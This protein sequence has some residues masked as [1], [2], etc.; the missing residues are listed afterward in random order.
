M[1]RSHPHVPILLRLS[2]RV[3]PPDVRE[4]VLGDL[5]E[6]WR[7]G[8]RERSWIRRTSWLLRQPVSASVA[9][10]RFRSGERTPTEIPR[11]KLGAPFSWLDVKLGLRMMVKHPGISLVIVFALALGIP[12]SLAPHHLI[13]AAVDESPPFDEGH[14]V[15][16]FLTVE[17]RPEDPNQ[18]RATDYALLREGLSSFETLGAA[19]PGEMNVISLEGAAHGVHGAWMSASSFALARVP[20]LM[21]RVLSPGDEVEGAPDVVV[22][23]FDFWRARMGGDPDVLGTTLRVGGVP[24]TVVGVMPQGFS[25]PSN[26]QLWLP[27]R[28]PT[29]GYS[30]ELGPRVVTY[31]RLADGVSLAEAQAEL[32][33]MGSRA[34]TT[35]ARQ[36]VRIEA[37]P[38]SSL[39]FDKPQGG[40]ASILLTL[41]QALPLL[42]LLIAC[43]NVGILLLARTATRTGEVAIRAALGAS[44]GRIVG[45][46]FVE[47][48][49]LALVATGVGL[50]AVEAIVNRVQPR[51]DL[52]FWMDLGVT[53]ELAAKAL[54]LAVF[55]AVVAGVLPALRAT[56]DGLHRSLQGAR[57]GGGA[58]RFGPMVTALVVAEVALG[59]GALFAGGITLYAFRPNPDPA[60]RGVDVDRYLVASISV[61]RPPL[62]S[63]ADEPSGE[64]QRLRVATVQEELARRL[65]SEPGVRGWSFSDVPVGGG[66]HERMLRIDG[67]AL[68]A[69]HPGLVGVTTLVDPAFF[70]ILDVEPVA[71]RLFGAADV[72]AD[73]TADPTV[74]VV[75]MKFLER[76]GMAATT[77]IGRSLRF[78]DDP[79]ERPGPW[80]EIVGAVPNVEISADRMMFDGTPM[81]Y[82]PAVT[83]ALQ[84]T[85]L[86]VDV[87]HDPSAFA[88][89]LRSLLADTDPTAILQNASALEDRPNDATV[90]SRVLTSVMGGLSLIAILLSTAALYALMALTVSQRRRE[91]GIR[92][93]LG[94]EPARIVVTVA[95]RALGQLTVGVL[96]GA[97][98]WVALLSTT[99]GGSD[100]ELARTI[101]R[102]PYVL[103]GAVAIV[104]TVGLT[105]CLTPALRGVRIRPVDALRAEG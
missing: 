64:E 34:R 57:G 72:P 85:T 56:R 96:L 48:L 90:V 6:H 70:E 43:G 88:P 99:L 86:T 78:T 8:V 65:G 58:L 23:G 15:V 80:M 61:P 35:P 24:T 91:I 50:F 7:T 98:F 26:E 31:G 97:G 46:L 59:L 76:R 49:L 93:A 63:S 21:G 52:P 22:I 32:R 10:L 67:D 74:V 36:M 100:G 103:L 62:G 17:G 45:Q 30:D 77:S 2:A 44:R 25:M 66:Q 68:P 55:S 92:I 27:L 13:D 1:S 28:L 11:G 12:A 33:V 14:D 9:R 81:V 37:V 101:A 20:P 84:P 47:A 102:W 69:D 104:V 29:A 5:V 19:L 71:G 3:L 53:A 94:G 82:L 41:A 16:G 89:R 4:E 54:F 87:G 51:L 75:N 42:F 39:Q 95:R 18:L 73:P 105:A 60:T 83:G 38:F 40:R 79:D